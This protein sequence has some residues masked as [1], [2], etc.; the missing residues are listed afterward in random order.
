MRLLSFLSVF[1]FFFLSFRLS[2]CRS[3]FLS[4]F[5]SF[6]LSSVLCCLFVCLFVSLFF[7]CLF[8]SFF[9]LHS[10]HLSVCLPIRLSFFLSFFL[11]FLFVCLS[12]CLSL[13][14]LAVGNTDPNKLLISPAGLGRLRPI[15]DAQVPQL[16]ADSLRQQHGDLGN[17]T[18]PTDQS[19]V[20]QL[21]HY[22]QQQD[23]LQGFDHLPLL[24]CREGDVYQMRPLRGCY[25][26]E[27]LVGKTL[28]SALTRLGVVVLPSLPDFVLRHSDVIHSRLQPASRVGVLKVLARLAVDTPSQLDGA[29]DSFNHGCNDAERRS[30]LDVLT[31]G[32]SGDDTDEAGHWQTCDAVLRRLKLFPVWPDHKE[33]CEERAEPHTGENSKCEETGW[34]GR[35]SGIGTGRGVY[36]PVVILVPLC[37]CLLSQSLSLSPSS[38]ILSVL[39]LLFG[40]F[41]VGFFFFFVPQ[42]YLWGSPLWVRFLP[43]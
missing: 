21:W 37:F 20:R 43:M 5:P 26:Y 10:I 11:S 13:F 29:I 1:L 25:V 18:V 27:R 16:L 7:V 22:L 33:G 9:L 30:L 17:I 6:I 38:L 34:V 19:W 8:L 4:F 24:P 2:V 15:T 41:F 3:F 35:W 42:L 40:F 14:L 12:V 39:L 32:L 23:S 36:C 28:T 31:A